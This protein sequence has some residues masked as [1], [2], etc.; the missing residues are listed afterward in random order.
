MSYDAGRVVRE[1]PVPGQVQAGESLSQ[2]FTHD[3]HSSVTE[4]LEGCEVDGGEGGLH[5]AVAQ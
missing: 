5:V 3:P 1:L 4:L 2:C